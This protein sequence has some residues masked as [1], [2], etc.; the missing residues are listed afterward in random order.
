MGCAACCIQIT[1]S[2][3]LPGLPHGKPGGMICPH[4]DKNRRCRLWGEPDYPKVC[5]EFKADISYCG[6]T[7]EEAHNFLAHLEEA[8][9]P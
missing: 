5:T 7:N 1:I 2:T 8:T 9:R 6:D 3:P 4:L